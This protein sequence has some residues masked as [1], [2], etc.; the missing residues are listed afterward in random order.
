LKAAVKIEPNSLFTIDT[1]PTPIN[2][3]VATPASSSSSSSSDSDSDSSS[4]EEE[5]KATKPSEP[6]ANGNGVVP[7]NRTQRRRLQLIGRQREIIR[8]SLNIA[9]GSNEK[10]E[11]LE[12]ALAEWTQKY[13]DK[14]AIRTEKKAKRKEKDAL[15]LRNKRGKL[16]K[17]RR[18]RERTKQVNKME[19]KAVK[20]V[21]KRQPAF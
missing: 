2:R 21:V 4:D 1:N 15:K 16:L 12:A 20:K 11:E 3:K 10:A 8:K 7:L 14:A 6:Q 9:P 5:T 13:D 18:L 19:K 17:G